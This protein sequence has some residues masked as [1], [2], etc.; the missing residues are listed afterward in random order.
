V[1]SR[2]KVARGGSANTSTSAEPP[3][4]KDLEEYVHNGKIQQETYEEFQK[5]YEPP[6]EPPKKPQSTIYNRLCDIIK[7]GP[8]LKQKLF[9]NPDKQNPNIQKL[10]YQKKRKNKING[11]QDEIEIRTGHASGTTHDSFDYSDSDSEDGS[12]DGKDKTGGMEERALSIGSNTK[13]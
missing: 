7:R 6:N 1:R 13:L 11:F 10:Q 12:E 2:R 3:K 5:L 4:L 8:G 9:Y